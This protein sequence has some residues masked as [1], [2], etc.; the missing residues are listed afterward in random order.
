MNSLQ[1]IKLKKKWVVQIAVVIALPLILLSLIFMISV[2]VFRE[3]G[4]WARSLYQIGGA[5]YYYRRADESLALCLLSGGLAVILLGI[6]Y[7]TRQRY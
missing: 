4:D 5:L 7:Y 3:S 1:N 6:A 2:G